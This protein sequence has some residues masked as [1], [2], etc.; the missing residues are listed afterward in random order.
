[1]AELAKTVL[2]DIVALRRQRIEE[3]RAR[4]PL[5]QLQAAAEAR[6]ERR[7]FAA[8]LAG[9]KLR[10][11]AELKRASPSRGLL[12]RDYRPRGRSAASHH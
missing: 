5:G 10:V 12:R 4:V 7:D 8:A 9:G 6:F 11:I 3:A 1:M 2:E